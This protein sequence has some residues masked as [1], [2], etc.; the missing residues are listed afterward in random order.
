MK[1]SI[2]APVLVHNP[3]FFSLYLS[4][5]LNEGEKMW[6]WGQFIWIIFTA[7][8][9]TINVCKALRKQYNIYAIYTYCYLQAG[10]PYCN[11]VGSII[12]T[13]VIEF[14]TNKHN[15]YTVSLLGKNGE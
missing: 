9:I 5:F 13:N 12:L 10:N 2:V 7:K 8:S 14:E 15:K 1:S 11:C 6:S 3:P 4:C